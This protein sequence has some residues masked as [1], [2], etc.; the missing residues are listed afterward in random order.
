M[1][2]DFK[3]ELGSEVVDKVTGFKGVVIGRTEWHYG[4]KRYTV[5]PKG[6]NKDGK[7][8]EAASFDEDALKVT[9]KPTSKKTTVKK[10]GGPQPEPQRARS[11]RR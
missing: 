6:T 10:T 1:A 5:Q 4:C 9:K 11:V 3:I 8:F 7:M 2:T